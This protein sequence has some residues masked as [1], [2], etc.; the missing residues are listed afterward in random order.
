MDFALL[1]ELIVSYSYIHIFYKCIYL[2]WPCRIRH[3]WVVEIKVTKA[4]FLYIFSFCRHVSDYLNVYK[5]V[6]Q[7]VYQ[8]KADLSTLVQMAGNRY[9]SIFWRIF[10]LFTNDI[11]IKSVITF[12][13]MPTY[14]TKILYVQSFYKDPLLAVIIQRSITC[15][16]STKIIY[17][18][19]FYKE[20]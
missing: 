13:T 8:H 12:I 6:S 1:W 10:R 3:V 14:Y 17:V 20:P 15:S 19:L 16:Y 18:Q 9:T 2:A 4:K 7:T 11:F 5:L